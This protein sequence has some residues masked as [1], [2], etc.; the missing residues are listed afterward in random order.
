MDSL[1]TDRQALA[2]RDD[3]ELREQQLQGLMVRVRRHGHLTLWAL[4]RR[5]EVV[6]AAQ[7]VR[8]R[9]HLRLEVV[10][11]QTYNLRLR[12]A[13]TRMTLATEWKNA[14]RRRLLRLVRHD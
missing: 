9:L 6:A 4:N 3:V 5:H 7:A 11:C 1:L 14:E 8:E 13:M 2:R 12:I 10:R